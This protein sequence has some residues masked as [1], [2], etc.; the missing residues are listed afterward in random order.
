MK[1]IIGLGNPGKKYERTRHNAGHWAVDG[2][3]SKV[4]NA[5]LNK[6]SALMNDSGSEVKKLAKGLP[7]ADLLIVHDDLD[8]EPG[9]WKLQ[10]DRSAAGHK[11]VQSTIDTLGNQEFWRLRIGIGRPDKETDEYVLEEPSQEDRK[12]IERAIEESVPRV[13]EWVE[14]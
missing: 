1:S 10:F 6:S 12:L 13:L 4:R 7:P 9:R 8:L 5:K 14:G 3:K 2:F 11:G